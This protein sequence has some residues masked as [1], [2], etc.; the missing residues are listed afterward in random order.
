MPILQLENPAF[1]SVDGAGRVNAGG[2]VEVYLA[3]GLFTTFATIY[4]DQVKTTELTNPVTLDDAGTKEIWYDVKVDIREKTK[5]SA[6]IRDTENLDPNAGNAVV[7]GFNLA[8]NGSFEIDDTNDGQPDTWTIS[9]YV[10]SAIAI[11]ET[12]VTDGTK[13]LEFNTTAAGTGGG[14]ATSAKFPVTEGSVCS[15]AWSFYATHVTTTNTFQIKWYDE[16]GVLKS[17]S[18]LTMPASGSVP[19][20]WTTYQ[21][22]VTVNIDGTQ[23]E[24]VLTGVASGGSNL[25]SKAYFDGILITNDPLIN[26]TLTS[27]VINEILD[28][29]EKEILIL[30]ATTDAVNEVTIKN[31]ET[32]AGPSVLATGDDTDINLNVDGKSGG[33]LK[34]KSQRVYGIAFLDDPVHLVDDSTTDEAWTLMDMS[35]AYPTASTAGATHAIVR[36]THTVVATANASEILSQVFVRQTGSS[37]D[38]TNLETRIS[39]AVSRNPA[40]D[41]A[42]EAAGGCEFT[43]ALDSNS[44]FDWYHDTFITGTT[45]NPR[46]QL[47]LVGYYV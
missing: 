34:T 46:I 28:S 32:G 33:F 13:A 23:G 18:D 1:I 31:R 17:T 24:I 15:V 11:T 30:E 12:I 14:V 45:F 47:S 37:L 29:N 21:E 10:G 16:D 2:T 38:I 25:S 3:D 8:N 27:P 7:Q 4:S 42:L 6:I 5:A 35:A 19:T 41:N 44:D 43:V 20:S 9:P 39:R 26:R 40:L 36:C 22:E